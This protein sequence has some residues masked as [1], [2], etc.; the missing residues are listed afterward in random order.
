[1]IMTDD[2]VR[3]AE[4]YYLEAQKYYEGQAE[5]FCQRVNE[6]MHDI[7]TFKMFLHDIDPDAPEIQAFHGCLDDTDQMLKAFAYDQLMNMYEEY[8]TSITEM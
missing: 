7:E 1:M 5:D 4:I 3:D 8:V 2:P 6:S